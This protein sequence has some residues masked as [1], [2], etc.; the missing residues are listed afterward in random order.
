MSSSAVAVW[1][2]PVILVVVI[3]AL[4]MGLPRPVVKRQIWHPLMASV[5]DA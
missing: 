3:H 2:L 5:V 4:P 1:G